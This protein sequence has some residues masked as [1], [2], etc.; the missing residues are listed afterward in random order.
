[1]FP[2]CFA[3]LPARFQLPFVAV[4]ELPSPGTRAGFFPLQRTSFWFRDRCSQ[5]QEL[6][7]RFSEPGS[8]LD[9][10]ENFDLEVVWREPDVGEVGA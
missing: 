6:S 1:M 4:K 3:A 7:G 9:D 8:R 10:V 5:M 2:E